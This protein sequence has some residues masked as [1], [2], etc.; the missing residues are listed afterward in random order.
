VSDTT[1]NKP[2][3][4][5][6]VRLIGLAACLALVV[7][8]LGAWVRLTDAGLG[9]PDWPGCYGSLI[10]PDDTDP[11][12]VATANETFERP[13]E[14]AKGWHEMIHRYAASTLGF[15]IL[16]A[17]LLAWRNRRDP[18]QPVIMPVVLLGVVI[19]QGLLGMW[20][21][22]LLLKPV[23]VMGHLLGG[24]TTLGMATWLLLDHL[25][26][27]ERPA[28]GERAA[29]VPAVIGLVLLVGQIAL[30]GWTS[31]NYAALACPDLP[32]CN[33]DWWPQQA[34]FAE[35]FVMWRG[36]GVDYEFGVL[37]APA[38][39]AIHWAHRIG[40]VVASLWLG[41]IGWLAWRRSRNRTISVSGA[42]VLT[43]LA[44][45]VSIGLGVVWFGL[46]LW[47]ATAHNG[48]AALLLLATINL[49]HAAATYPAR[50]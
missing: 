22:T 8:V 13:L 43:A 19:F 45:Q 6:Y 17:A 18:A 30:G 29:Y 36:L 3:Y 33:G 32:T 31:S 50:A 27:R 35:G 34:D 9:C 37:E 41:S 20:T 12:A 21:V 11:G 5:W 15:A 14:S 47:L 26:R 28:L 24:L 39:V 16:L 40:A 44:A 10:V 23:I 7:V 1:S 46:P 38:R 48:V 42:L 2:M 25:R 4:Q 49:N